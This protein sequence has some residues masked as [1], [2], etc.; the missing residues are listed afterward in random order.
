MQTKLL[1][2]VLLIGA[3]LSV[4]GERLC[5]FKRQHEP[6][7]ICMWHRHVLEAMHQ[8]CGEGGCWAGWR[9][10]RSPVTRSP[11]RLLS[12]EHSPCLWLCGCVL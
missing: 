12:S 8:T 5:N 9:Q 4:N 10:G 11:S 6:L 1:L 3:L 2:S 7:C